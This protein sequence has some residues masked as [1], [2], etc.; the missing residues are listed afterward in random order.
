[1]RMLKFRAAAHVATFAIL[2][3]VAAQAQTTSGT[4]VGTVTD[5]SGGVI[6]DASITITNEATGAVRNLT[7][8]ADG[9]Y[10]A[11]LLPIGTYSIEAVKAGFKRAKVSG[12]V[13]A[14]NQAARTDIVLDIGGVNQTVEV[15]SEVNIVQTDRSDVGQVIGSKQVVEL[16]LNGRNFIQLATLSP[17]TISANKVDQVIPAHGGGIVVNG[18]STNANQI[19]LD[20]VENQDFLIPRVGVHPSPDAIAEFKVMGATYSAE[21]GRGSGANINLVIK[22][23]TNDFH[24][25]AFWFHRNDNLD[26]RNFFDTTPLPEFKRNQFGGTLG[27]PIVKNKTFFFVSHESLRR[28][29]GLTVNATVPTDAQRN[30]N[31]STGAAIYDPLTTTADSSGRVTRS[32]FP[33]NIIPQSR[34]SAQSAK[35]LEILWP[36]AQRQ[37]PDQPNGVFNPV[38]RE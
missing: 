27:G 3:G 18:A 6:S 17:G 15:S 20:G 33:G 10:T 2:V 34:I 22:S 28:G 21:Y 35:A 13:L 24:G 12:V 29:K 19:T 1:M 7:T 37:I 9:Q 11:T 5:S 30:G 31:L 8:G 26:A 14:V 25:S 16:P 38:E 23:G 4:I 36:R 32:V